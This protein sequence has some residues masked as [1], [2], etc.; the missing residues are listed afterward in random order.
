MPP[1]RL[2]TSTL[3][4]ELA[5]D[6]RRS[7]L[8]GELN[9]GREAVDDGWDK[10][11]DVALILDGAGDKPVATGRLIRRA[12]QWCLDLVAVLPKHRRRGLGRELV[13][14]LASLARQKGALHLLALA[15][16]DAVPFFQA[17]GFVEAPGDGVVRLLS[18]ELD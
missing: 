2:T 1:P 13:D 3:E 4:R 15:S 10:D 12:E 6:L 16:S 18:R 9:W 11:A 14:F 8:C 5:Q 7:I 17:C